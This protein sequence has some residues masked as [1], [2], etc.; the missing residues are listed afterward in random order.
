MIYFNSMKASG[1]IERVISNLIHEWGKYFNVYLVVKDDGKTFYEISSDIKVVSLDVPLSLNMKNRVQRIQSFISN[2]IKSKN[3]L[4]KVIREIDP[5]YIYTAAPNN[6]IE[7]FLIDR[8]L[9]SKIVVSEHG[10]F[11][12]YNKIYTL[13]K[14]FLYPKVYCISVPNCMDTEIYERWGCNVVY[15]PHLVTYRDQSKNLLNTK[16]ILNIGRLTKDK[17]QDL[18]LE[19]WAKIKDKKGWELWIVGDGEEKRTLQD[20]IK[21][22]ALDKSVKLLP[23]RKNI[24]KIYQKASIFVFSSRYEGFGMVL[25]EAMSFGIPCVS[26]DCPSGPRDIINHGLNGFLVENGDSSKFSEVLKLL[27]NMERDELKKIGQVAYETVQNWD[28]EN[29]LEAWKKVFL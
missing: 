25:L 1:G 19:I 5:D 26:F 13:I 10:S 2:I 6:L 21:Y 18:L 9:K 3:K 12:G 15:I 4:R 16:V 24:M 28:N 7:L 17:R 14:K 8:K 22:L 11:Y 23:A 27:M 29:I 20:K